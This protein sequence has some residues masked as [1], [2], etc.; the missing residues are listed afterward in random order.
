MNS[1]FYQ[2]LIRAELSGVYG[3]AVLHEMDEIIGYYRLYDGIESD[4]AGDESGSTKPQARTNWIKKLINDESRHMCA[5]APELRIMPRDAK[6]QAAADELT[7]WL[8]DVLDKNAWGEQLLKGA[9]DAFIGKRVALKLAWEDG[10]PRLRFAPSLEFIYDT[11]DRDPRRVDKA[12]FFYGTTPETVTDKNRQRIWR[13][14]YEMRD[15]RCWLDEGLYNGF[16]APVEITCENRDTG[17]DF[18]PVFVIVN[19]GLSGDLL[20]ESDVAELSGSQAAYDRTKSDDLDA[21]KYQMFGQK[22]FTDASQESMESIVIAPNAMIDLQTDASSP[23][24]AR[25][26]VLETTFAYGEHMTQS[27]D[28]IQNDMHELLSVPRITPELLTGLGTSGKAM[29][30]LYWSLNCRCEERWA[31]GWDAAIT[32]MVESMFKL[33]RLNGVKLPEL[34]YT[35]NIEHLYPIM[36]DE[37]EERDRDLNEVHAQARSRRSYIEKWQPDAEPEGELN[38]ILK[39]KRM[40][41]DEF[42]FGLRQEMG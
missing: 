36:D 32:W 37:E 41:G 29:R 21:L 26:Q 6:D 13:Q 23:H 17:L 14:R 31:S 38:Q 7:E 2:D 35:L 10:M 40:L 9:R 20:G 3:Y 18:V 34:V 25:A 30:A 5:R 4:A 39:E 19:G 42:G 12:V 11:G 16:G 8:E 33:A 24:Q 28:R 27:L 1:S 22:V 15:G